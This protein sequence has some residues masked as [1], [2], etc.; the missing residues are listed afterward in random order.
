MVMRRHRYP[1]GCRRSRS[2]PP[3]GCLF[4]PSH[5][6]FLTN[7][8]PFAFHNGG[9]D[10]FSIRPHVCVCGGGG[11]DRCMYISYCFCRVDITTHSLCVT[12]FPPPD[13]IHI[14]Y[15]PGVTIMSAQLKTAS[16]DE[17]SDA[18]VKRKERFCLCS[19]E[20]L[21]SQI[22]ERPF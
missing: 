20:K 16:E 4:V 13:P 5:S 11:T 18:V 7:L 22:P 9:F 6:Y 17:M 19:R 12:H 21:T 2:P 14:D 1:A 15:N 8:P 3:P 10:H